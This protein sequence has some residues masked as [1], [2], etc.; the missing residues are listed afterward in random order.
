MT[1]ATN[2]A[3]IASKPDTAAMLKPLA[4]LAAGRTG[5]DIE[6]L[7]REVRA[8]G[9]RQ[10]RPFVW[11]DI[12]GALGQSRANRPV[13]LTWKMA[14]HEIGHAIAYSVLGLGEVETVSTVVA[15]GGMVTAKLN[16]HLLQDEVGIMRLA[17]CI[18]AGR[19]AEKLIFG[20]ALVGSGGGDDSDLAKATRI[21]FDAEL[22]LGLAQRQ[23]L[24]YRAPGN[25]SEA[26]LYNDE[27]A[28]RVNLRLEAAEA[29]ATEVLAAHRPILITLAER[30]AQVQ[31]MDGED[32]RR[33]LA[34]GGGRPA[35]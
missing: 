29:I 3:S 13:E 30:L 8:A 5:A 27:L 32:V 1:T 11:A 14:I 4:L 18:L 7:V 20:T 10:K 28:V 17:A 15:T 2:N 35:A 34:A 26:L 25:I 12:E 24:L 22:S 16:G 9:R 23:P 31:V 19:C 6:R 21:A 33:A